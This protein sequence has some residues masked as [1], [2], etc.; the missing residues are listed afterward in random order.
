MSGIIYLASPYSSPSEDVRH[1]R[2]EQVTLA[3]GY[4]ISRGKFVYSP[5]SNCHPIHAA[6]SLRGDWQYWAEFD[7]KL[8]TFCSSFFILQ[9]DGWMESVGVKAEYQ[10]ARE[11]NKPISIMYPAHT[12]EQYNILSLT[13]SLWT[14]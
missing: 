5:I 13:G 6:C 8:I 4:L 2:F 10:I 1:E 9:I 7:R 3:A 14:T 11:L 12:A